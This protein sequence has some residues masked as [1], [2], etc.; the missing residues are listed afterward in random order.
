[1]MYKDIYEKYSEKKK[2]NQF[3]K[4]LIFILF[5]F[6]SK[7]RVEKGQISFTYREN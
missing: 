1:M 7:R 4:P 6:L 2:L 3:G 5:I